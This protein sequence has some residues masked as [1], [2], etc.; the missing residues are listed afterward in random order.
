MLPPRIAALLATLPA[1]PDAPLPPTPLIEGNE[2]HFLWRGEADRVR[3]WFAIE[4]ELTRIPGTD[5]WHGSETYPPGFRTLYCLLLGD[6]PGF[7]SSPDSTSPTL[8]DPTNPSRLHFPPTRPIPPTAKP[9]C[10]SS[11]SRA[12]PPPPG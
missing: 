10:P 3:A 2:V 9:G 7:P 12:P 6:T 8:L 1:T 5:L 4:V 11:N